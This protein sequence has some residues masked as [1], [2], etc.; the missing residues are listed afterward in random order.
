MNKFLSLTVLLNIWSLCGFSQNVKSCCAAPGQGPNDAFVALANDEAFKNKHE[1]PEVFAIQNLAGEMIS[2]SAKGGE[3]NGY[4]IRAEKN[5][6][7]WLFVFHEWWGLNDYVKR[8]A[9]KY[10]EDLDGVNV[11]CLD[12]Y[13]GKVA[14]TREGASELM[15]SADAE[16]IGAIIEGAKEYVGEEATVGTEGWCFGGGWSLQASIML[17]ELASGCVIYYGMPETDIE[18]LSTIQTDVL[19][20]FASKD[21]WINEEVVRSFEKNAKSAGL[22]LKVENFDADHAF[23]N[24]SNN[25]FDEEAAREAYEYSSSFLKQ[26]LQN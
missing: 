10:Y 6:D 12:L 22:L 15:Q 8:E 19:G 18:R 4:L 9:Q 7:T 2:I 25:K 21:Q 11:L 1:V 16:R 3:T 14:T 24:P 5:S 17:G 13:D 20:I 26:Y 23:A